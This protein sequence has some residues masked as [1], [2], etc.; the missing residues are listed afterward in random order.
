M[1][2]KRTADTITGAVSNLMD[3]IQGPP[4]PPDGSGLVDADAVYWAAIVNMR[5]RSDW[6]PHDLHIAALTAKSMRAVAELQAM[7]EA[8]GPVRENSRGETT[9][10]PVAAL[11]DAATR[12]MLSLRRSLGLA[13]DPGDTVARTEAYKKARSVAKQLEEEPLLAQ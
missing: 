4:D 5:P 3:A 2:R 1:R 12:R 13:T 8:D 9:A 11:L 7:L 10:N 6:P